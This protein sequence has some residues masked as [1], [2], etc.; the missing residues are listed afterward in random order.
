MVKSDIYEKVIPEIVENYEGE[1]NSKGE[2]PVRAAKTILIEDHGLSE[3]EA[4][5]V[6]QDVS[7]P[8]GVNIEVTIDGG[9]YLHG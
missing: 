3:Q 4:H 6:F 2:V 9:V 1:L 7:G 5:D 8:N